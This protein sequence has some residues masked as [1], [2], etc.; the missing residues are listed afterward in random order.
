MEINR[1]TVMLHFVC[2][3]TVKDGVVVPKEVKR[4]L[5]STE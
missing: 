3:F 5:S 2:D 4:L 1:I